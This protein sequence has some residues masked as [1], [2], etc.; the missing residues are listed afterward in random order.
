MD[1]AEANL[2]EHNYRR[3]VHG[4]APLTPKDIKQA[5]KAQEKRKKKGGSA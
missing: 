1:Y 3:F 4:Q 5:I 2:R